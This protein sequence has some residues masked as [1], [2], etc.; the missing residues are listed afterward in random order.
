MYTYKKIGILGGGQLGKMLIQEGINYPIEFFVLDPDK[1]CPC[2][3]ICKNFTL[4]SFND[5]ESVINFGKSLDVVTIEIENVNTSALF[6]LKKLGVKVFPEPEAIELIKDKGSQKE[7]YKK[8]KLKSSDFVYLNNPSIEVSAPFEFPFFLKMRTGGYDGKGVKKINKP[9]DLRNSF[10]VPSIA[11][12]DVEPTKEIAVIVARNNAGQIK[13]FPSVESVFVPAVH[14][15][16][17]LNCPSSISEEKE[18]EAQEIAKKIIDSLGMT[19]ILAVEFF[20]DSKNEIWINEIAPRPHNSGHQ[21]IEANIT[22][23]YEQLIRCLLNLP[24]GETDVLFNSAMVN[25]LGDA[26]FEGEVVYHGLEKVLSQKNIFLHL[27]G[28][29]VSKPYRKMGHV[30][31]LGNTKKEIA[32]KVELVKNNLMSKSFNKLEN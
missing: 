11:E 32:H 10:D 31:I 9:S 25:I 3:E 17:Y 1:E 27:Y 28:K 13:T 2:A 29:K 16:D 6:E 19:G 14:L 4:G 23:Q 24:L 22:S 5:Y 26:N 12:K 30:T 15:V 21:S 8:N 7:F 18:R 20:I